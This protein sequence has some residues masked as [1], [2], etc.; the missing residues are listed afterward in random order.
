MQT[1]I[2]SVVPCT[3]LQSLL[4]SLVRKAELVYRVE[5]ETARGAA[6]ATQRAL[7]DKVSSQSLSLSD[8]RRISAYFSAVLRAYAF[9]QGRRGD[10]RYRVQFKVASLVADLRSVGTPADRIREE[11][12]SFFG[13]SGLQMLDAG[14]VA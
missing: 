3:S 7:S 10:A 4:S 6:V 9:K 11:V 13:T 5:P 8:E 1:V 2:E 14:E 12:A